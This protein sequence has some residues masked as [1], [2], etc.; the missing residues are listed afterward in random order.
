MKT[1]KYKESNSN[2]IISP[3]NTVSFSIADAVP[4]SNGKYPKGGWNVLRN[5][6]R[7]KIIVEFPE[8]IKAINL[9][10]EYFS[11]DEILETDK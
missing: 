1:L 4:D 5:P 7:A 10:Y 2:L 3:G 8:N 6:N 11:E 9:A